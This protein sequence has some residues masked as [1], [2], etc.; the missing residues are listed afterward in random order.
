M[1]T[2]RRPG[3]LDPVSGIPFIITSIFVIGGGFGKEGEAAAH[4]LQAPVSIPQAQL[5]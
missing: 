3:D 5:G 4:A 2:A 1:K